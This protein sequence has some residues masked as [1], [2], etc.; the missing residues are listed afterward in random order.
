MPEDVLSYLLD[1]FYPE[2]GVAISGAHPGFIL[3]HVLERCRFES[4]PPRITLEAVR[5]AVENLIVDGSAPP[6]I[7]NGSSDGL[8]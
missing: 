5:D 8:G 4:A 7:G 6:R 2:T 1:R 3:E